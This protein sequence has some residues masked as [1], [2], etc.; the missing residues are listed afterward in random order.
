VHQHDKPP[1]VRLRI[2]KEAGANATKI[3]LSPWVESVN[4]NPSMRGDCG[5][6]AAN[7]G[8]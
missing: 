8:G 6:V 5:S 1:A 3:A 7:G 2:L 4:T